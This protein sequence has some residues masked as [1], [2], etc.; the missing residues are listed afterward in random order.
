MYLQENVMGY[1]VELDG[2]AGTPV[3]GTTTTGNA[4]GSNPNGFVFQDRE[5]DVQDVFARNLPFMLDLARSAPTPD[6]PVVAPRTGRPGLRPGDVP[7]VLRR[8]RRP[9]RSTPSARWAR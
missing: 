8:R 4:Y 7:D 3:G 5:A 1:T 2:G 6:Q 9:S